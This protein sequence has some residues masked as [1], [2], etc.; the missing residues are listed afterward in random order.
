MIHVSH[1]TA[2]KKLYYL[3]SPFTSFNPVK[4]EKWAEEHER[5]K[6]ITRIAGYLMNNYKFNLLT[7]ITA[8]YHLSKYCKLGGTWSAWAELDEEML[9]RCDGLIV[10]MMPGWHDSVGLT[11]EIQ[12]AK[13][14]NIDITYFNPDELGDIDDIR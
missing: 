12:I 2:K 13:D 14:N 9:V 7:P 8:S 3:G 1:L 10:A 11:A 5:Y 4:E 6:L